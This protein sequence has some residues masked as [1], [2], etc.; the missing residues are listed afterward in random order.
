MK[1]IILVITFCF[2][3]ISLGLI[4]IGCNSSSQKVE[5]AQDNVIEANK[6]LEKANQDYLTD[7]ENYKKESTEKIDANNKSINDFNAR[8]ANEK[9]DA[10]I[11][12][13][14]KIVALEQKNNDLK[15]R[16][17]DYKAEGKD[18]WK[19]F[20]S[21]FNHDMN[22]LNDDFKSLIGTK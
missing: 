19:E 6:D 9:A 2:G 18:Q 3:I 7:I 14:N 13:K 1:K 17:D 4:S 12:Y 15:K 11:A 8:I 5:D 21:D 10:K 16:L 20:K 22:K